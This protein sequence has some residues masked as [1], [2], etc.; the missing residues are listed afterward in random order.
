[1]SNDQQSNSYGQILKSTT[2]LGG[3]QVL[4]IIISI[5]RTKVFAVLLGPSGIGL[6]GL[7][8]AT[9][10]IINTLSGMGIGT[11]GVR[12]IAEAAG[13]GDEK[14]I[15]STIITL[16]RV[17]LF[18]GIIGMVV[19]I[20]FSREISNVTFGNAKQSIAIAVLSVTLL[21]SA[22]S[23]GQL[24]LIQGL[25]RIT[26][27]AIITVIVAFLTAVAGISIVYYMGIQGV[28]PFL[29]VA[30][31]ASMLPSWWYARKISVRPLNLSFAEF[32]KEARGLFSLGIVFMSTGFMAVA[33]TYLTQIM[34]VRKIG[35]ESVGLYQAATS[36]AS[37]YIG[38]II[39]AMSRDFY[40][41]L[42]AAASDNWTCNRLVNEQIEVGMLLAIPGIL[43]TLAFA[44]YVIHLFYSAAFVI[45]YDVLRWQ[46]LGIFLRVVSWPIGL[47]LVAKGKG[48]AFF[49]SEFFWCSLHLALVWVGL[50]L[51]GLTGVGIAFFLTYVSYT[52]G[53]Y[54][55][56]QRISNFHWSS[57]N[58]RLAVISAGCIT[59]VFLL[60]MRL[61]NI[62]TLLINAIIIFIMSFYSIKKLHALIGNARIKAFIKK[63]K[64]FI[65][66]F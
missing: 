32:W 66:I 17:A 34:V 8:T 21:F 4:S 61:D 1:M 56:V 36:L 33:L 10:S 51:F 60:S 9:F 15:A 40:P 58:L 42:T 35:M 19:T 41:R 63:L 54:I 57:V 62:M 23:G 7:Y 43:I 26:E 6:L 20:L 13:S 65:K 3:S 59:L 27:I 28:V 45:A 52:F 49:W 12:Q 18:L 11:S 38:I 30:S 64:A 39:S 14:R 31:I 44:P 53:I 22:I 46:I 50:T 16:R 37:V 5:V 2:L 55:I 25:R 24:A 47:V 29:I 48:K